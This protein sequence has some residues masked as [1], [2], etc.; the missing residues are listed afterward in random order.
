MK[1]KKTDIISVYEE[2]HVRSVTG[3][4]IRPGGFALTDR[5]MAFCGFPE[6]SRVLDA[7]CGCGAT[8]RHLQRR[9]GLTATGVDLSQRLLADRLQDGP[10]ELI[11][12]DAGR[13][14]IGTDTMDGLT[15]E[16]ALSI[17]PDP[18]AVLQ[19]YHRV[20]KPKG[21][22]ILTDIY[23]RAE[24]PRLCGSLPINACFSGAVTRDERTRQIEAAGFSIL[25]WEDHTKL[26]K[27]LAARFVFELGSLKK[28]WE[29]ILPCDCS[30]KTGDLIRQGKPGYS[31]LIAQKTQDTSS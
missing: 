6:R 16:C 20:L 11:R 2:D 21:Y 29:H 14:P 18:K 10:L 9:W 19:E 28:F 26:L 31:L 1:E 15:C 4:T 25:L 22:L 27:E 17:M 13:L 7:G 3:P 24:S 23:L 8:V 5:A 12:G 30:G